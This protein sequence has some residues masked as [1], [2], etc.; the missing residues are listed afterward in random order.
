[1]PS[2][3]QE[4]N[5]VN[6]PEPADLSKLLPVIT[7]P[8]EELH[9]ERTKT[10]KQLLN[11]GHAETAILRE[12][13]LKFHTHLPHHLGSAYRLGASSKQLHEAYSAEANELLAH[14]HQ[15][16][17]RNDNISR[18]NWTE[19]IQQKP[20]A[21]A[22]VDFFDREV[23]ESSGGWKEVVQR[24]LYDTKIPLINGLTGG[25]G[26][27]FIH[28]AY[29]YEFQSA[30][31]ATEA[32]GLAC[33]ELDSFYTD[34]INAPPDNSK[35]KTNSLGDIV[36]AIHRDSRFDGL[37]HQPGFENTFQ[38]MYS[39]R[40]LMLEHWNAWEITDPLQQ[41]EHIC[42]LSV[43]LAIGTGDA[44]KQYDFF[45]AHLMTV[46]HALRVLWHEFPAER[47]MTILKEYAMFVMYIYAAQ[48]R[49]PFDMTSITDFELEGRDWQW[50]A[51]TALAHEA[52]LDAHF[53]KVVCAP[54][55]FEGA[56]GKKQ[57]FYLKAAIKF[58]V[59]FNGW[60][61]FGAGTDGFDPSEA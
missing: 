27:P 55:A 12:P 34:L 5:H 6:L 57:D 3:H 29:A 56:F 48:L 16:F 41:L 4:N 35:Y 9:N 11:D 39:Q 13:A 25:L 59:E 51:T 8:I 1:M 54:Q 60:T 58:I 42:D 38:L 50:V 33:T 43:L 10:L 53:F 46:A 21:V 24:Y 36:S 15:L 26:H 30:A 44:E 45:L 32:L 7:Y 20:Q 49:R 23:Q 14:D 19:F 18:E 47:R 40:D 37:L 2:A 61:G 52:A 22:Y 31:V 28:L 17:Y